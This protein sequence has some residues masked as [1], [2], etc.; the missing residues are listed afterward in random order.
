MSVKEILIFV[1]II[2]FAEPILSLDG[3]K[4]E[5]GVDG[6]GA[7]RAMSCWSRRRMELNRKVGRRERMAGADGK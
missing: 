3:D 7:E 5:I 1:S 6:E 2:L 4:M